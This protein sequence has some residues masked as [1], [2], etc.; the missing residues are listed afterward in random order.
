[1][2]PYILVL[3]NK[4]KFL[5]IRSFKCRG[6]KTCGIQLFNYHTRFV[7]HKNSNI[8]LM[9]RIIS[10]GYGT[11]IVD[12]GAKLQIGEKVYFN[13]GIKISCKQKISIG[14]GCQFGPD[15]KIFDNNH[16]FNKLEGVLHTHSTGDIVIGK[17][18]WI[19]SN[20][21]ILK[22]TT[23]GDG[24]VIGAGCVIKGIIPNNSIVTCSD[25]LRIRPI[26]DR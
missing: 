7:A 15:V 24:C 12:D 13:E 23:I 18:C 9:D 19:A 3:H 11:I 26:E 22:G 16:K 20:V 8:K 17:G 25:N 2:K 4:I 6:L 5:F 14:D 1:M 21:V 10:D